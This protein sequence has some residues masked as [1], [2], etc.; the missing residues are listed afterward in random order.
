MMRD[1]I[2]LN[3]PAIDQV[4]ALAIG[5]EQEILVGAFLL[6]CNWASKAASTDCKI[7]SRRALDNVGIPATRSIKTIF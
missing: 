2:R 7:A 3:T 6:N 1:I 4:T 5:L